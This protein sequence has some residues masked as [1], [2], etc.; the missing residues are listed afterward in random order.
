MTLKIIRN[1]FRFYS[2]VVDLG[3]AWC[4][5]SGH[6][7]SVGWRTYG[8]DWV[9]LWT[10]VI[11]SSSQEEVRASIQG[12]AGQGEGRRQKTLDAWLSDLC[13]GM[14]WVRKGRS[15]RRL[16]VSAWNIWMCHS[17]RTEIGWS[18]DLDTF[19]AC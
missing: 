4:S 15:H 13:N 8:G 6:C 1:Y 10:W 19:L 2:S 3:R 5:V 18:C 12:R 14:C 16:W 17:V 11:F 7:G 9:G